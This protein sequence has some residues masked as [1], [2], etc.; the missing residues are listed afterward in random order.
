MPLTMSLFSPQQ[1]SLLHFLAVMAPCSYYNQCA[2]NQAVERVAQ[3]HTTHCSLPQMRT[4]H[5]EKNPY[6]ECRSWPRNCWNGCWLYSLCFPNSP[7][8]WL[9]ML[10]SA[11][12]AS[13]A[14]LY[15]WDMGVNKGDAELYA[16]TAF[17]AALPVIWHLCL[18][19]AA[20]V[21]RNN[22]DLLIHRA[23]NQL[24]YW[25]LNHTG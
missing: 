22:R 19:E 8:W 9:C 3:E 10:K 16:G 24:L 7:V 17:T 14:P 12:T 2:S 6:L 25:L 13:H 5:C 4:P 21:R 18:S 20:C 23:G 1:V 15:N 11:R